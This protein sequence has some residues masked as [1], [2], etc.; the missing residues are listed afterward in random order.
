MAGSASEH[1]ILAVSEGA[2]C[3]GL[4]IFPASLIFTTCPCKASCKC[5]YTCSTIISYSSGW[6]T[7]RKWM[8]FFRLLF[9][10][11]PLPNKNE[12]D[13][14]CRRFIWHG[15][16]P[17]T[18]PCYGCKNKKEYGELGLPQWK[19]NIWVALLQPVWGWQSLS[20]NEEAD[21]TWISIKSSL[22]EIM[23]LAEVLT[24][25]LWPRKH[26]QILL[27]TISWEGGLLV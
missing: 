14:M 27:G 4:R 12:L 21:L 24:E 26:N 22:C 9:L 1:F 7:C 15:K 18:H 19:L 8:R 6:L 13:K 25:I 5:I 2:L 11:V 10:Q 23:H 20:L 17:R 16:N 3:L